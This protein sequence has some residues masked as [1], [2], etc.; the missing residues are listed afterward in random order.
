MNIN[1]TMIGQMLTFVIFVWFCM[2]FIWPPITGALAERRKKIAD[3]LNAAERAEQDL[4]LAQERATEKLKDAKQQAANI[5]EQANKR[6]A[7]L[8]DE[9]KEQAREEGAR[10]LKA[11]EAESEQEFNR[12]REALRERVA[13]VVVAGAEK[14]LDTS[15]DATV[16]AA[17]LDKLA[18]EL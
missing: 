10:I 16:H 9:A 11:A 14:I 3:G 12:A 2:K 17:M 4:E 15:V 18:R 8:V 6:G 5:I 13:E 1:A 7:Q